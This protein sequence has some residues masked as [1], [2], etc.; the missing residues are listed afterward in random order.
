M[1][2][3]SSAALSA[4]W[5]IG[6]RISRLLNRPCKRPRTT[7]GVWQTDSCPKRTTSGSTLGFAFRREAR[8]PNA[9]VI[10]QVA[11]ETPAAKAGIA[12]R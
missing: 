4:T 6:V 1:R 3:N 9:L 5:R 12:G 11:A 7:R 2:R 10:V 8:E